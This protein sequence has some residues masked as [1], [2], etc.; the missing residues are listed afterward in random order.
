MVILEK[1][2]QK[3]FNS[4]FADI[5]K[6]RQVG[7]IEKYLQSRIFAKICDR[8][9]RLF[10]KSFLEERLQ[11][12]FGAKARPETSKPA[13]WRLSAVPLQQLRAFVESHCLRRSMRRPIHR[14]GAQINT[15]ALH[16]DLNQISE[17]LVRS[18]S[19]AWTASARAFSRWWQH[20]L[21][22]KAHECIR[23]GYPSPECDRSCSKRNS[24][25]HIRIALFNHFEN[26]L[27]VSTCDS[28]VEGGESSIRQ[29][30]YIYPSVQQHLNQHSF[31]AGVRQMQRIL[32]WWINC[33]DV[34][35]PRVQKPLNNLKVSFLN[36]NMQNGLSRRRS[37]VQIQVASPQQPANKRNVWTF[38]SEV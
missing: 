23:F 38:D 32:A 14:H 3:R 36:C 37:E 31:S 34:H 22:C 25:I 4:I 11:I 29:S 28:F 30:I 26:V 9:K 8:R 21:D 24:A 2:R 19:A 16:Y 6:G 13:S 33:I 35:P 20:P 17:P 27:I 15:G 18:K 12:G 7:D 1:V 10:Q 5:W